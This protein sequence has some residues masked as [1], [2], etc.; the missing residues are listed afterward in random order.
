MKETQRFVETEWL[1]LTMLVG[2]GNGTAAVYVYT[3]ASFNL[4]N[5]KIFDIINYKIRKERR[6]YDKKTANDGL[7]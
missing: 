2:T 5:F 7:R 4:K 3:V 6:C 1:L